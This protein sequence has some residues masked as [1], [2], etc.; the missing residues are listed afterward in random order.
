MSAAGGA[1]GQLRRDDEL[2]AAADLHAGDALLPAAHERREREVDRLAAVPGAVELVAGLVLDA[3][4]VHL[5]R[6]AGGGFVAGP[7]HDV[8][9]LELGGGRAL[10]GVELGLAVEVSHV[11]QSTRSVHGRSGPRGGLA[12]RE[13][14]RSVAVDGPLRRIPPARAAGAPEWFHRDTT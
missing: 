4:V 14:A 11:G 1:V 9:D 13:R 10:G 3:G 5:D 12:A 8:G 2:A 7:L 6:R